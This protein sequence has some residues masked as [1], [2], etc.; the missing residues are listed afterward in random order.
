MLATVST[1]ATRAP[2]GAGRPRG[3][4]PSRTR[5]RGSSTRSRSGAPARDR[6]AYSR[7]RS[8]STGRGRP[9]GRRYSKPAPPTNPFVILAGWLVSVI[10]AVWMALAH[11]VGAACRA[12][13][14]SARGLDPL[15]RRDGI[16]LAA[17]IATIVTAVATWWHA[18]GPIR[19][20]STTLVTLLGS[21]SWSV[22]ILL[23]LLGWRFLRPPDNNAATARMVI[24]WT[25]L[26]V[27]S[28]G[29]VHVA[30]G[31]PGLSGGLRPI[32][33]AGGLL[34]YAVSAPL[35]HILTKWAATPVLALV[36]SFGLLV[37]TGTP[38]HRVPDRLAEAH[39]FGRRRQ[40]GAAGAGDGHEE[41][42]E[43][44]RQLA[45][46][47]RRR[48]EALEGGARDRAYDTPP[49]GGGP[50]RRPTGGGEHIPPGECRGR[51]RAADAG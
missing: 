4:T 1:M 20:L 49:I 41:A 30:S 23:A 5:Q 44:P 3:G 33:S 15:H 9:T 32:K 22:P 47:G 43:Q 48:P 45:R 11:T 35:V 29:L 51:A 25:A 40:A 7:R 19:P 28:L 16:G 37:I 10:S 38:L 24:G 50:R 31:T 8:W 46:L 2:K 34:G 13:G 6:R 36:A 26:L 21:G 39:G 27:G 18:A 17:I 14:R 42:T 12:L